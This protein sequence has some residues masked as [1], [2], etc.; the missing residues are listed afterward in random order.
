MDKVPTRPRFPAPQASAKSLRYGVC[1]RHYFV[2]GQ[3]NTL[4]GWAG[5]APDCLLGCARRRNEPASSGPR[6]EPEAIRRRPAQPLRR[7]QIGSPRAAVSELPIR[8]LKYVKSGPP[9]RARSQMAPPG[10]RLT[11]RPLQ[12]P[13]SRPPTPAPPHPSPSGWRGARTP[14]GWWPHSLPPPRPAA[15]GCIPWCRSRMP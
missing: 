10:P 14:R 9:H 4:P 8:R 13:D 12:R 6:P 15:R 3:V 11:C 1:R 2:L 5:R 7:Q